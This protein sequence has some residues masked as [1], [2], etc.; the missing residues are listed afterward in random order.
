MKVILLQDVRNLGKKGEKI[1]VSDGYGNNFLI[2]RKLAILETQKNNELLEKQKEEERIHEAE[3]VKK[4]QEVA[5]LLKDIVLEFYAP[6]GKDGRMFGTISPKQIEDALKNE[7]NIII[8]KRK[9]IDKYPVNAFGYS[10]LKIELHKGVEGIVNVHV[11]V[12]EK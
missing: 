7:K 6:C 1:T 11:N 5:V 9:F 4:A 8:D 3:E 12:K 2:P 10:H